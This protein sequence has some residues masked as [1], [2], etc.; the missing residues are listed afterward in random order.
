[1]L[2]D[3]VEAVVLLEAV[4]VLEVMV[5]TVETVEILTEYHTLKK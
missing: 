1:M 5:A 2:V 4:V 3:Q